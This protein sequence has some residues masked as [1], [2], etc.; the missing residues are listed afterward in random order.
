MATSELP[1]LDSPVPGISIVEDEIYTVSTQGLDPRADNPPA[2]LGLDLLTF[3]P[4]TDPRIVKPVVA[5]TV[6]YSHQ[7]L[8]TKKYEVSGQATWYFG[9][10]IDDPKDYGW[11]QK[12]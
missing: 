11:F 8:I 6:L 7:V 3:V 4:Y 10:S 5:A 9:T 1:V 12:E 2:M